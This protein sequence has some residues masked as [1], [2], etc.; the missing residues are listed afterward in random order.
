MAIQ[1]HNCDP[2]SK[3]SIALQIVQSS[4]RTKAIENAHIN[5]NKIIS[6]YLGLQNLLI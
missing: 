6:W 3:K 5:P 2:S 1:A 4:S